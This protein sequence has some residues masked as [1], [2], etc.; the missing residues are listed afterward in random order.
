M[1]AACSAHLILL[2]FNILIIA[3][4]EC[5]EKFSVTFLSGPIIFLNTLFSNTLNLL[6][7]KG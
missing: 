1:S 4:E 3:G 5:T 6:K 2:D 7:L